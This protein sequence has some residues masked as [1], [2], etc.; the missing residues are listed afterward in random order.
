M[1]KSDSFH[2]IHNTPSSSHCRWRLVV[3]GAVDGYSRIPVFLHCSNNNQ[4]NT[5]M[6]LFEEAV[7]KYGLPSRIRCDKGGENVDVSMFLLT[8]P[9]QRP[10]RGTVIVGKSVHNQRIER[11]WRDVFQGF[12]GLYYDLFYYLET[13]N[14]LVPNND[15]HLFCLHHV[16]IPRINR[17]LDSWKEAWV[18][19]PM[20]TEHNMTPEQLW[21]SGLLSISGSGNQIAQEVFESLNEVSIRVGMIVMKY[22]CNNN[23]MRNPMK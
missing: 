2:L 1:Y 3:H 7:S 9:L 8:H 11:M 17:H 15:V 4:A 20:R 22:S 23:N 19:H 21:T 5:V 16:F 13:M 10:G 12:L 18:K 14:M 6:Q